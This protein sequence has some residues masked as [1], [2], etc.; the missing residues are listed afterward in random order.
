MYK[1]IITSLFLASSFLGLAQLKTKKYDRNVTNK[2]ENEIA[3]FL[4]LD[5]KT[6]IY[7]RKRA[8]DE[9]WKTQISVFENNKWQRPTPFDLLNLFPKQRFLGSYALN[10]D[11][12]KVLFVSKKYGGIGSFDIWMSERKGTDNWSTP[13][14]VAK[15]INTL[16]EEINPIFSQDEKSIYFVRRAAG[17]ENGT[18]YQSKKRGSSLWGEPVKLNFPGKYFAPRIAADN[19]TMYLSKVISEGVIEM[20]VSRLINKSWSQPVKIN[21][22]P[23]ESDKFFGNNISSTNLTISSKIDETYDLFQVKIPQEATSTAITNLSVLIDTHHKVKIK[24]KNDTRFSILSSDVKDVYLLNDDVY[25]ISILFKDYLPIVNEIDLTGRGFSNQSLSPRPV[26]LETDATSLL[27]FYEDDNKTIHES[28]F[29]SEIEALKAFAYSTPDKKF[30]ITYYQKD[31]TIDS[32]KS[33]THHTEVIDTLTKVNI[34]MGDDSEITQ[35]KVEKIRI[36][37]SNDNSASVLAEIE[38]LCGNVPNNIQLTTTTQDV[39]SFKQ[40]QGV[41]VIVK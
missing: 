22:F 28:L 27:D 8:M 14:N 4:S 13:I 26:K 17:T 32:L 7:T 40:P 15:P 29:K 25:T 36:R 33:E 34:I 2:S 10:A 9:N 19:K 1:R 20:Y 11:A 41:F 5:G 31:I 18:V 23:E 12:T 38:K 6:L 30:E 16:Q 24:K 35:D 21:D 39:S 37:Y 3:P